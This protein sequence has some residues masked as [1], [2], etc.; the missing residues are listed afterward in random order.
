MSQLPNPVFAAP[1]YPA[2]MTISQILDRT[3]RLL[4]SNFWRLIGIA[5][6][7]CA[8]ILFIVLAMEAVFFA[9]IIAQW[10]NPAPEAMFESNMPGFALL[11]AIVF[12]LSAA[13]FGIYMAATCHASTQ[14][15]YGIKVTFRQAYGMAWNRLGRHIWLLFWIYLRSFLPLLAIYIL[16]AGGIGLL[17]V[18]KATPTLMAF[19]LFP[20]LLLLIPAFVYGILQMLRLSLAFPA[21]VEEGLTA[22][23]SIEQSMRLT[24]GAKGRIFLVALI[25]YAI[26]YAAMMAVELIVMLLGSIGVFAAAGLHIQSFNPWGYVA[27]GFAGLAFACLMVL[28]MALTYAALTT[29]LSVIYH[30]QRLRR[31]A[32]PPIPPP[33][34]V[35]A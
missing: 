3:F 13:I 22:R 8:L 17:A 28:W 32:P 33:A 31:D 23:A 26:L 11:V 7:P 25:I 16:S 21:C 34:E 30:D 35:L 1:A 9:P 20:A 2:P 4:R 10:P 18:T 29:A 19:L 14:A 6:V 12:I 24:Q 15:D 27:I 5:A